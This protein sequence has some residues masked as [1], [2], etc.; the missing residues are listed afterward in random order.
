MRVVAALGVAEFPQIDVK[1]CARSLAE[2]FPQ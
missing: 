1:I 2:S